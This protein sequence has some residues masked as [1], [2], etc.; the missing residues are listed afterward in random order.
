MKIIKMSN[1]E[2]GVV[3]SRDLIGGL[4]EE[5][6]E[7]WERGVV[8]HDRRMGRYDLGRERPWNGEWEFLLRF[9]FLLTYSLL[10]S[11]SGHPRQGTK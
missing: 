2:C 9:S 10:H 3:V 1:F 11:I 5:G 6:T 7:G 8:P 4:L